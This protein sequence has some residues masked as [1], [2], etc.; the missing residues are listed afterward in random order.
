MISEEDKREFFDIYEMFIQAYSD[1]VV[2]TAEK[3]L[4]I[5]VEQEAAFAHIMRYEMGEDP[6]SN[7]KKARGHIFR[8]TLDCYKSLWRELHPTVSVIDCYR[9][10]YEGEE[11]ELLNKLSEMDEAVGNARTKESAFVGTEDLEILSFWKEAVMVAI[12]IFRRIN[13][14]RLKKLKRNERFD[15][16]FPRYLFPSILCIIGVIATIYGIFIA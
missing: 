11:K 5:L 1:I 9:E 8:G 15:G 4:F 2:F 7:F 14:N 13:K 3:P 10:A 16:M 6:E 12:D